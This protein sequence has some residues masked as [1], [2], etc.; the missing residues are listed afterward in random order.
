MG[1]FTDP[2]EPPG[3]EALLQ[4]LKESGALLLALFGW[5]TVALGLAEAKG[6]AW[7]ALVGLVATALERRARAV[8]LVIEVAAFAFALTV[9]PPAVREW[10]WTGALFIGAGRAL[11]FSLRHALPRR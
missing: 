10:I 9:A 1:L 11:S 4:R 3:P 8:T 7:V 5:A 6:P 2:E